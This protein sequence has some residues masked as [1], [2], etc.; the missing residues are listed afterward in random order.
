MPV[1]KVEWVEWV[2]KVE[3]VEEVEEVGLVER[4][5]KKCPTGGAGQNEVERGGTTG[6]L[7][8]YTITLLS[9]GSNTYG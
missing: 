4:Q 3:P 9:N 5:A 7:L 1:E 8:M 2:E 6:N